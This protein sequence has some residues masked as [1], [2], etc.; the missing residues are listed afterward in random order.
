MED[1]IETG[2]DIINPV[3]CSAA[4]MDVETLKNKYGNRISF[5]GGEA[6]PLKALPFGTPEEVKEEIKRNVKILSQVGGYIADTVHN[7]QDSTPAK[8][9]IAFFRAVNNN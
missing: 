5:W 4:N 1:F 8:N 3:Q 6:N 2:F 7:I 9:I